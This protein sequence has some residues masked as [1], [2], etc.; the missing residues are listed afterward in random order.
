MSAPD[1][2]TCADCGATNRELNR[3]HTKD[4]VC[5]RCY[6]RRPEVDVEA[7][8]PALDDRGRGS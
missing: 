6:L 7:E 2:R 1:T 8:R 4:L 5:L 3:D